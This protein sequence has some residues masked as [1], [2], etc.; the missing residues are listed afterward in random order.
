MTKKR[1]KIFLI[2]ML[3]LV[4]LFVSIYVFLNIKVKPFLISQLEKSLNRK[5]DIDRVILTPFLN[6][7][8]KNLSIE[9]ILET[10]SVFV[11]P[12]IFGIL[13]GKFILSKLKIFQPKFD[14]R[15]EKEGEEETLFLDKKEAEKISL[16]LPMR[17]ILLQKVIIEK[18]YV[19]FSDTVIRPKGINLIVKELNLK[20]ENL[21]IPFE[22]EV[23]RFSLK[24]LI[25]WKDEEQKGRIEATG[26]IDLYRK[27]MQA[28]FMIEGIDGVYMSPYY[29]EYLS[30]ENLGI[31][32][33]T[34]NFSSQIQSHRND[35]TVNCQLEL[36][37]LIFKER[38]SEEKER[39]I[40]Q[41][42]I[43]EILDIFKVAPEKKVCLSFVIRTKMDSP[44]FRVEDIKVAVEEKIAESQKD[45]FKPEEV[46]KLP[47]KILEE[48]IRGATD[49][50]KATIE[51]VRAIGSGIRKMLEEAFRKEKRE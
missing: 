51:G 32:K 24:G 12:N 44:Q 30:L 41:E 46:V 27:D 5:V 29:S 47:T 18:G 9:R 38:P 17:K 10:E 11:S 25:P 15:R 21:G 48:I 4:I 45:K 2:L 33:V 13:S 14:F 50:S 49:I 22:G 19:N 3:L 36:T 35:L 16:T 1:L 42:M 34:L 43:T 20:I 37:D 26:W 28:D 6:L 7:E 40:P 8:I 23:S 39:I 31:E